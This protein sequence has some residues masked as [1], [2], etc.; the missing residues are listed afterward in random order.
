VEAHHSVGLVERYHTP[1]RRA[2]DIIRKELP[3]L[4]K[5]FALQTAMK[6]VNDTAGPEGIVPTLLVFGAYPRISID[7]PPFAND[8]R[9]R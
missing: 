4:P 9:T 2:Y 8:Y 1:L 3:R 6:A 7:E 5:Q